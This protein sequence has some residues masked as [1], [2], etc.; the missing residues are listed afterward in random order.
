[1]SVAKDPS[2]A[3]TSQQNYDWLRVRKYASIEPSVSVGNEEYVNF[4]WL[5]KPKVAFFNDTAE[6]LGFACSLPCNYTIEYGL[7]TTYGNYISNSTQQIYWDDILINGLQT[8]KV[9]YYKVHVYDNDSHELT[10]NASFRVLNSSKTSFKFIV[11]GSR[12]PNQNETQRDS[13]FKQLINQIEQLIN[14]QEIDFMIMLG[15]SVSVNDSA[16]G[17]QQVLRDAWHELDQDLSKIASRVPVYAVL[18]N[19]DAGTGWI[20]NETALQ[21]FRYYWL[22]GHNGNGSTTA[23]CGGNC[24]D[25]T[26]FSLNLFNSLFVFLNTNEDSSHNITGNQ[27]EWLN[28]TLHQAASHKF[29]FMHHG[30]AVTRAGPSSLNDLNYTQYLDKLFNETNVTATFFG[31]DRM[32]CTG[33]LIGS[34]VKYIDIGAVGA[35]PGY[36]QIYCKTDD[37][38]LDYYTSGNAQTGPGYLLAIINSTGIRT[39]WKNLTSQTLA[40]LEDFESKAE[41]DCGLI[42]PRSLVNNTLTL[43]KNMQ[44]NNTCFIFNTYHTTTPKEKVIVDCNGY[45]II[46]KKDQKQAAASWTSHYSYPQWK[47]AARKA[48]F[49]N[50]WFCSSDNGY[51]CLPFEIKNCNLSN[52]TISIEI[53]GTTYTSPY[54]LTNLNLIDNKYGAILQGQSLQGI[55]KLEGL[56]VKDNEVGVITFSSNWL[57]HQNQFINN[58][59]KGLH[60]SRGPVNVTVKDNEFS[61]NY[62]GIYQDYSTDNLS[63]F[64]NNFSSNY[65]G[66][67]LNPYQ[68]C[69]TEKLIYN[70]RFI[71]NGH[72]SIRITSPSNCDSGQFAKIYNNTIQSENDLVLLTGPGILFENNTLITLN[73]A[74]RIGGGRNKIIKNNV[75]RNAQIAVQVGGT[76]YYGVINNTFDSNQLINFSDKGFYVRRNVTSC[77]FKNN[78]LSTQQSNTY[79]ILIEGVNQSYWNA[80]A[81]QSYRVEED[82]RD[83]LFLNNHITAEVGLQINRQAYN[84]TLQDTVLNTSKAALFEATLGESKITFINVTFNKSAVDF[85]SEDQYSNLTVKWYLWVQVKDQA[86]NSLQDASVWIYNHKQ[87]KQLIWQGKTDEVLNSEWVTSKQILPEYWQTKQHKENLNFYSAAATKQDYIASEEKTIDLNQSKVFT[88]QLLSCGSC[89][90]GNY[91]LAA[92]TNCSG[93]AIKICTNNTWL[94]CSGHK[95]KG[96][97]VGAGINISGVQD[98]E[99]KNCVIENFDRGIELSEVINSSFLNNTIRNIDYDGIWAWSSV[100]RSKFINNSFINITWGGIRLINSSFNLIDSNNFSNFINPTTSIGWIIGLRDSS[101]FNNITNNQIRNCLLYTS[102]SPRD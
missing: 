93:S 12:E 23:N 58:S 35:T 59:D 10:F 101:H 85:A 44:T 33:K 41:I 28:D 39:E 25:E 14:N 27:L 96:L 17:N 69:D 26:T 99:V 7:T 51:D 32:Y 5:Y 87:G 46:G 72:F 73:T 76:Y 56:L 3:G 16:Y 54:N 18:G 62:Y 57:I 68:S 19:R 100:N 20:S 97:N 9:Y 21:E 67:Y 15:S 31:S 38:V 86:G 40:W 77:I 34:R 75:I 22:N 53:V 74:L 63:I 24:W 82:P 37:W 70:N 88:I 45:S 94:N 89:L 48:F 4:Y 80:T 6:L 30:F 102:P 42:Y 83:N 79:G 43:T 84:T 78:N 8:G 95:L 66:L 91:T 55:S 60:L 49:A 92:D 81:N 2:Q 50:S 1:M 65:Y 11:L 52:F 47:G 29:I 64:N 13:W 90:P 98:V 36:P 61:S 71:N